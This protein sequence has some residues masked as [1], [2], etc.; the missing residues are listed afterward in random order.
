MAA[1]G[2]GIPLGETRVR[3]VKLRYGVNTSPSRQAT[4]VDDAPTMT[5][6]RFAV[7]LGSVK[8]RRDKK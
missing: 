3:L 5:T 7:T 4:A 8:K 1:F 6:R 2:E